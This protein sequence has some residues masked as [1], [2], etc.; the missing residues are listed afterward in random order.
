LP[1]QPKRDWGTKQLD[2]YLPQTEWANHDA[3][4]L[5]A[6]RG[7]AGPVLIDQG[8]DDQFLDLLR[9]ESLAHAMTA[10]RQAGE[11]RMQKGYDHSYYFVSTFMADHIAFH[12]E[13]LHG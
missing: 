6:D 1:T 11:F 8:T 10:R 4:L 2:A 5:M 3:S 7:F 12:A 13:A 9:P